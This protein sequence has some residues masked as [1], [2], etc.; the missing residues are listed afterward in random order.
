MKAVDYLDMP[1]CIYNRVEVEMS[2]KERKIY[3]DFCRDMVVQIGEEEPGCG[4][5]RRSVQ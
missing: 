3:D 5:C 1:E 2:R 4:Q